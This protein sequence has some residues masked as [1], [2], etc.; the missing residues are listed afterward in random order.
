MQG[1][2]TAN[3]NGARGRYG[4]NGAGGGSDAVRYG[5]TDAELLREC[6][7]AVSARGD[8]LLL[9]RTKDG[10]AFHVRILSDAGGA[11]YYPPTEDALQHV[12]TYVIEAA[13]TSM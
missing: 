3:T 5:R 4:P 6:V 13:K 12:L 9:G 1:R 8:A 11:A 2:D 7:D 10:S